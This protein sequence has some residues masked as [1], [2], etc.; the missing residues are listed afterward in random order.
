[1]DKKYPLPV[2]L[3]DIFLIEKSGGILPNLKDG[4]T[5]WF[6]NGYL[7]KVIKNNVFKEALAPHAHCTMAHDSQDQD[8]NMSTLL[9]AD[10][11]GTD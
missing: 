1:M 6:T 3:S 2:G 10:P 11:C 7:S 8:N 5:V 9:G 4:S